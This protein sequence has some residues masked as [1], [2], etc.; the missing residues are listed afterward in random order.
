MHIPLT[1]AT[2]GRFKGVFTAHELSCPETT[3]HR[4][5]QL[6]DASRRVHWSRASASRLDWL[7]RN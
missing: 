6:H 7:Q 2:L 5:T 1:A 3:C 4:S